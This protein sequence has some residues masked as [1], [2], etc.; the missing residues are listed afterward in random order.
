MSRTTPKVQRATSSGGYH[1]PARDGRGGRLAARGAGE[2]AQGFGAGHELVQPARELRVPGQ[3]RLAELADLLHQPAGQEAAFLP[4]VQVEALV[5]AASVEAVEVDVVAGRAE[6]AERAAED[7]AESLA[8]QGG[9]PAHP[10]R[11][12]GDPVVDLLG[13]QAARF[14][15]V[16]QSVG[17]GADLHLVQPAVG[18]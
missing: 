10:A 12:A 3:R 1:R 8:A 18:A 5:E 13:G 17:H 9:E 11:I 16:E 4:L 14:R 6:R 2:G 7:V 15:V